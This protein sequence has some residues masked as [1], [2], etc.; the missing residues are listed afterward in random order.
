MVNAVRF[1]FTGMLLLPLRVPAQSVK[2]VTANKPGART[3][4]THRTFLQWTEMKGTRTQIFIDVNGKEKLVYKGANPEMNASLLIS[5]P[6]DGTVSVMRYEGM[7][8]DWKWT[9]VDA[10]AVLSHPSPG[11]DRVDFDFAPVGSGARQAVL[12]QSLDKDWK[13]VAASKVLPWHPN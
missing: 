9:S 2:T 12:F 8:D 10:H 11:I 7:G 6:G 13:V 4:V 5:L 1:A 3:D